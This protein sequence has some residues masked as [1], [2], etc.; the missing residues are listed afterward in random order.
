MRALSPDSAIIAR[1]LIEQRCD[2]EHT[3]ST[4]N[5]MRTQA[6][7]TDLPG[8][9]TQHSGGAERIYLLILL[10]I[11]PTTFG[12][13]GKTVPPLPLS[14]LPYRGSPHGPHHRRVRRKPR[15]E[16]IWTG[17]LTGLRE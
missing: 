9:G 4:V 5:Y 13:S 8:Y 7:Q 10:P 17:K 14:H 12:I 2:A 15:R 3:A 16:T 6:G 11:T 1:D